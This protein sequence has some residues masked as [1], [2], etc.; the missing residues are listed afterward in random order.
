MDSVIALAISLEDLFAYDDRL[1]SV[2]HNG[3]ALENDGRI[4]FDDL[5]H[6]DQRSE[7]ADG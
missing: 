4:Q 1:G 5:S 3:L 6:A 7:E 2:W